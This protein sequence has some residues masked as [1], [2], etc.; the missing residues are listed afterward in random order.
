MRK[1]LKPE[2]KKVIFDGFLFK[3][4]KFYSSMISQKICIVP[5]LR[6]SRDRTRRFEAFFFAH[7]L[8]FVDFSLFSSVFKTSFRF[9]ISPFFY[10]L[11]NFR[12]LEKV[13]KNDFLL[14]FWN[15]LLNSARSGSE[16]FSLLSF[17]TK[18][19]GMNFLW[20]NHL[21]SEKAR[22]QWKRGW[23]S[24]VWQKQ[25][26]PLKLNFLPALSKFQDF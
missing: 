6:S 15:S 19:Y 13:L 11:N 5:V 23:T 24:R 18:K 2:F 21:R 10:F 1:C 20:K 4:S 17:F 9:P 25:N 14:F 16:Q 8:F 7:N 22:T 3:L 26:L 12:A